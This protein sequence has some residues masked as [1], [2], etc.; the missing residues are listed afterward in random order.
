MK[1]KFLLVFSLVPFISW[2]MQKALTGSGEIVLL[3]DNGTWEYQSKTKQKNSSSSSNS[4]LTYNKS[5]KQTLAVK[6]S[7]NNSIVWFDP[8]KW[9]TGKEN[10][11]GESEFYLSHKNLPLYAFVINEKTPI[12]FELLAKANLIQL[13]DN[14]LLEKFNIIQEGKIKINGNKF[15][16]IEYDASSRGI[17]IS[18][19]NVMYSDNAGTTQVIVYSFNGKLYEYADELF[20]FISGIDIDFNNQSF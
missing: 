8:N 17:D 13:E 7:I 10:A 5:S 15:V 2:S 16:T 4:D 3:N 11:K 14:K 18:Y 1:F 20:E 12:P 19:F 6:S 9:Q